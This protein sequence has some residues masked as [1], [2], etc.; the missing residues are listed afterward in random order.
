MEVG[1]DL[2]NTMCTVAYGLIST[3]CQRTAVTDQRLTEA[4]CHI[5]QLT[6]TVHSCEA[7]I[8][9]LR[10]RAGNVNMPPKFEHN[11]GQVDIQVSS[12]NGKNVVAHWIR[13][14]GN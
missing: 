12:H 5:N 7:K 3:V 6:R 13:V 9:H 11:G 1:N 10:D 8:R 2:N 14:I 4:C